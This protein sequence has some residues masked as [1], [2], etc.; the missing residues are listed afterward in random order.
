MVRI[1]TLPMR[2]LALRYGADLVYSEEIVDHKMVYCT[3]VENKLLGT[4]DYVASDGVVVFRTCEEEKKKLIFQMGTSDPDRALQVAKMIEN[5]VSGLDI[6][7]GCPKEFS[8]KGGMGA[9]LL[10]Q[11]DKVQKILTTLVSGLSIPVTCKIRILPELTDTL[12]LVKM[13]EKTGVKAIGVHGRTKEERSSLPCHDDYIAKISEVIKIPVIANGGSLVIKTYED[14]T[15]FKKNTGCSSVMLARAAQW[16]PSIF[17]KDGPIP[18]DEI[19]CEYIKIALQ[20]DY[21]K[22]NIKYVLCKMIGDMT[23][24]EQYQQV[25]SARDIRDIC[26]AFGLEEYR[27][28]L[29]K[30]RDKLKK[31]MEDEDIPEPSEKR[32]KKE[33][34][35]TLAVDY[36]RKLY[37]N[38]ITPLTAVYEYCKKRN[39]DMPEF[40]TT[41]DPDRTFRSTMKLDGLSYTTMLRKRKK[42]TAEQS[43]ALVFLQ[44]HN[45]PDGRV[46]N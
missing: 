27:Q 31:K 36:N 13:I 18:L 23:K 20:Y 28:T 35:I 37:S 7:M 2:L 38:T 39:I 40:T 9:A 5:D 26:V 14:I 3:R 34:L 25:Q 16:N 6:N 24:T 8:I 10:T 15:A 32:F 1:G 45:I 22:E 12:N 42:K 44:Y 29:L 41:E 17:R 46:K 33:H 21:W 19:I 11:P 30:E 4:I 43:A